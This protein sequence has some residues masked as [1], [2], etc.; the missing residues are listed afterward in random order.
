MRKLQL[1][2][3]ALAWAWLT[4]LP[5]RAQD[6]LR[7]QPSLALIEQGLSHMYGY[8]FGEARRQ[9]QEVQAKYPQHPATPLI[10]ALMILWQHQPFADFKSAAFVQHFQLL[11]K[12]VSLAEARL[13]K[14]EADVEGVYFKMVA[15]GLLVLHYNDMGESMKAVGETK[16]L[17][18]LIKQ[19]FDLRNQ[20][21]ELYLMTGL[22]NYY[23]EYY[24]QA[25]PVYKPVA[26][27][28][29]SGSRRDG[30]ADLEFC[31]RKG[32]FSAPEAEGYL[33]FINLRYEKNPAKALLHSRH[34][35]SK[36]PKNLHYVANLAETLL[37][38][39]HY[40]E[41]QPLAEQLEAAP[42]PFRQ[43]QGKVLGA[44]V[45]E[46][47]HKDLDLASKRYH[48][49]EALFKKEGKYADPYRVYVYAGLHRHYLRLGNKVQ[50]DHY[51]QLAKQF[52]T[53]NYLA[54]TF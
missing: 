47:H 16:R 20:N 28:F 27:F 21:V 7:D 49:A 14:N 54:E 31:A 17:Y 33:A 37:L 41:A 10:D 15:C 29:K 9:F 24:P 5:L 11:E 44:M 51:R 1:F 38:T 45:A 43:A 13:A 30:L 6:L 36:Y 3:T 50:A 19:S 42:R 40:A 25:H 4:C 23:R 35:V 26:L 46:F 18:S 8:E 34:L 12:T 39:R 48:Q 32:I 53:H 2:G 22:Y 52:D